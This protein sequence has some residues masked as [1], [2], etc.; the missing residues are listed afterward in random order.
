M[1]G[2]VSS[3]DL[4][5]Y[6]EQQ[7]QQQSDLL[8]ELY[9]ET[10]LKTLKP[11][12]ASGPLQGRLLS[13]ISKLQQP[14]HIVEIG[15]FTGYATLCLA[16]GLVEGGHITT[17]E[18]NPELSH[19]SNKYFTKSQWAGQIT[20]V[21]GDALTEIDNLQSGIDLVFIDAK[22]RDYQQ[23]YDLL[24]PKV[25]A[26]G[27]ILA[28]NILWDG[29]V[30][31]AKPDRTTKAIIDFNSYVQADARVTNMILPLR[32]GVNIIMKS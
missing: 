14:R 29:K 25:K 2:G 20:A 18:V 12:M 32:D 4:Y 6:C 28:D 24:L 9:R 30:L 3:Q 26:G 16:E 10:H 7:S 1:I 27:I 5:S 11:R 19:I 15:T 31:D 8:A 22:K 21:V 17:I 23:Y 13:F